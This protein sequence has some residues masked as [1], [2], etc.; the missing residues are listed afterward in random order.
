MKQYQTLLIVFFISVFSLSGFSQEDKIQPPSEGKAVIYFLRTKALGALM[1][2]RLFEKGQIIAKYN[3]RNYVRYECDPG[4]SIFWIKAENIDFI[5]TELEAGK[6][7]FVETNAVLGAFSAG[8]KFNL[9]DYS[10]E[11]QMERINKL[12]EEKEALTFTEEE[13]KEEQADNK[14]VIQRGMATV[15]KKRNKGKKIKRITSDMDY[16]M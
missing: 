9:V 2:F 7:Y 6:I 8:V 5:E 1:N 4:E 12:L 11:K 13:L 14:L 3:G 16:K 10:D 15:V